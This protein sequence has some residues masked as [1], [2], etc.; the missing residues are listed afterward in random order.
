MKPVWFP[1]LF[2]IL[3]RNQS[4]PEDTTWKADMMVCIITM[5]AGFRGELRQTI[6]FM[7]INELKNSSNRLIN[8]LEKPQITIP[9]IFL[10]VIRWQATI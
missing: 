5:P 8:G 1:T 9:T 4:L 7:G 3:I 2:K 10:Q 6:L